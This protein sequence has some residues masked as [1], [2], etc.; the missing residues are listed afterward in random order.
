LALET[1]VTKDESGGRYL[2]GQIGWAQRTPRSQARMLRF[3]LR[4]DVGERLATIEFRYVVCKDP[5]QRSRQV[6]LSMRPPHCS[7]KHGAPQSGQR[8]LQVFVASGIRHVPPVTHRVGRPAGRASVKAAGC[9]HGNVQ[10]VT[11]LETPLIKKRREGAVLSQWLA[12]HSANGFV[13]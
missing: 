10:G 8:G 3:D 13:G 1:Q 5:G 11:N 4:P 7:T 9:N 2:P 6:M 12:G